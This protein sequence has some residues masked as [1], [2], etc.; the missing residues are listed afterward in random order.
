MT[1]NWHT[2]LVEKQDGGFEEFLQTS[3]PTVVIREPQLQPRGQHA[4][5]Q[6]R[7]VPLLQIYGFDT[8]VHTE[9]WDNQF[10][11]VNYNHV[12]PDETLERI[13]DISFPLVHVVT[14]DGISEY[15]E[16]EIVRRL[17]ER[18]VEEDGRYVLVTDTAAPKTPTITK[19]PGKS[20][21]D[22]F[23]SITVKDYNHLSSV[24]LENHLDSRIPIVDTRNVFF[25]A[26]STIH[27]RAGA[28]ASSVD[29]IFDYTTAPPESPVWTSARYFIEHDLENVLDDYSERIREA[30]RSWTERGDTQRAA[31]HILEVLQ[32]CDYDA[33]E[34]DAYRQRSP[35]YR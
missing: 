22:E 11:L 32:V 26:A 3:S 25:H 17:V 14:Q 16:E 28:P 23:P 27:H 2:G 30:L 19:K 7:S 9:L 31:N 4:R 12:S 8:V 10:K 13:S 6:L 33:D 35:D 15:G 1:D 29:E 5:A 34:L 21:V 18:S 20:I 24:F